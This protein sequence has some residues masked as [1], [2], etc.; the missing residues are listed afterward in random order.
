MNVVII[1]LHLY[2][3]IVWHNKFTC[4]VDIMRSGYHAKRVSC[5]KQILY[6]SGY[7]VIQQYTSNANLLMMLCIF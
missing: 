4:E 1:N 3:Y 2:N 7:H 6:K 5:K